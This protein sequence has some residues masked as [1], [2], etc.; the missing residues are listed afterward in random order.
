MQ[1][2][3]GMFGYGG[4]IASM[5]L[6]RYGLMIFPQCNFK[7]SEVMPA[8]NVFLHYIGVL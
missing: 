5:H 4:P 7:S 6:G 1:P 3:F 2:F 8:V